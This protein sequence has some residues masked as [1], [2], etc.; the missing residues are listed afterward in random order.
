M[1]TSQCTD[2]Q[3]LERLSV[4]FTESAFDLNRRNNFLDTLCSLS[5][6][7]AGWATETEDPA[8][9]KMLRV[10]FGVLFEVYKSLQHDKKKPL[11][12]QHLTAVMK[13]FKRIQQRQAAFT[14]SDRVIFLQ[15]PGLVC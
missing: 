5:N 3:T 1:T 13:S 8:L 7:I 10:E 11:T 14:G 6:Q 4:R 15:T 9:S 12:E 2:A